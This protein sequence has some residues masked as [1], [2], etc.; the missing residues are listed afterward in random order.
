VN[1]NY[2]VS[3]GGSVR[4]SVTGKKMGKIGMGK[5][6]NGMK[7]AF[8]AAAIL[9]TAGVAFYFGTAVHAA[10]TSGLPPDVPKAFS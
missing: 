2:P 4:R 6:G 10:K 9:A 5:P 1:R 8:L 7:V 3:V